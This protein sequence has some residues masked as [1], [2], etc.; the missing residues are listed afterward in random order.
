MDSNLNKLYLHKQKNIPTRVMIHDDVSRYE[1]LA[2][3]KA[4]ILLYALS[5]YK[6]NSIDTIFGLQFNTDGENRSVKY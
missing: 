1:A 4:F 2:I 5:S 3:E 6:T